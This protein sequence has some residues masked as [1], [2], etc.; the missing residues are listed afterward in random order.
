MALFSKP[1]NL[2][3]TV[4]LTLGMIVLVVSALLIDRLSGVLLPFFAAWLVAYMLN[5]IVDFVQYKLKV[6]NRLASVLIV[7]LLL[8]GVVAGVV[9]LAANSVQ[10]EIQ[11]MHLMT[12]QYLQSSTAAETP[13]IVQ[14]YLRKLFNSIDLPALMD[15]GNLEN[16]LDYV[17]PKAFDIVS[18]SLQ[19]IAGLVVVFFFVLYMFFIMNDFHTLSQE[20]INL[21]PKK[22]RLFAKQMVHDLAQG[23]DTYFRR[24]AL[25]SLIVGILFSIGFAI[26]GLPMS[27]AMGMLV[28]LLNMIPY[29]HT[30]GIIPPIIV[31]LVQSSQGGTGFWMMVIWIIVV[32]CVIQVIL[33]GFLTP[34]I[35]GQATGLRPAVILL[36]LTVW[37]ALLGITGMII[38]LPVTT[39]LTSYYRH[40]IINQ[41][42]VEEM[43][44]E[45]GRNQ[46]GKPIRK[47]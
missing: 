11:K 31:A 21:V 6:K 37:G 19:Y 35:M 23:M 45:T 10:S 2:D 47:S 30:L 46:P 7:L 29:M 17:I 43:A 15:F 5:P 4:R 14:E 25:I 1:F 9:A 18:S 3:R 8:I 38:A 26:L 32:F 36:S 24:Q 34:K 16:L 33:D 41:G 20:W 40:Y 27:V 42:T 44:D 12:Q 39:M 13:P 22:Y 28:G